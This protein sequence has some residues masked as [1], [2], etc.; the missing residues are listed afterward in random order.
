MTDG[1]DALRR[2]VLVVGAAFLAAL[3]VTAV[4]GLV[5]ARTRVSD[6]PRLERLLS[7]KLFFSTFTASVLVVLA[8]EYAGIYR[9][10]PTPFT[11]SLLLFSLAL[12]LYALAS[13]PLV[14]LVLG[15]RHAFLGLG[16]GPFAF[17]PDLFA[18]VAVVLLLH[19]S[20]Q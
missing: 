17:L 11:R 18:G 6:V 1:D 19:Q 12:L 4:V 20:Y 16:I 7:L 14:W 5:L 13:N 15:L 10:L 8:A 3:V 9:E 2:T